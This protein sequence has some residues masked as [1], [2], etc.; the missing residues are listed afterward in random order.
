MICVYSRRNTDNGV[1][2]MRTWLVELTAHI[3]SDQPEH[4]DKKYTWNGAPLVPAR[5]SMIDDRQI[6]SFY[7][8]HVAKLDKNKRLDSRIRIIWGTPATATGSNIPTITVV[9]I[10]GIPIFQDIDHVIQKADHTAHMRGLKGYAIWFYSYYHDDAYGRVP[11]GSN[12]VS[13]IPRERGSF[14]RTHAQQSSRLR[15]IAPAKHGE[16]T[17]PGDENG[18]DDMLFDHIGLVRRC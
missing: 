13:M 6:C 4:A 12:H 10:S 3:T 2:L 1:L 11:P 17:S 14:A 18:E 16:D 9:I 7:T 5:K 15:Q 8:A